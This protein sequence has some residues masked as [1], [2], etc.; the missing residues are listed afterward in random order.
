MSNHLENNFYDII[1]IGC[2]LSGISLVLE[3]CNRT[4][5]K[6]LILEKKKKLENDK[7]WCF[8]NYPINEFTNDSDHIW[9]NIKISCNEKTIIKNDKKFS[10]NNIPSIKLYKKI[11]NTVKKYSNLDILFDQNITNLIEKENS[12]ILESNKKKFK[13]EFVFDS[14]PPQ[15][16]KKK[17]VQHFLGIEYLFEKKIFNKNEVTLM[18]F[19]ENDKA[20]HFFYILPFND[21]RALIETTYFSNNIFNKKKYIRDIDEYIKEKFPQSKFKKIG[22]E[23]G[24]IPMYNL[25]NKNYSKRIFTIGTANNWIRRSSG[26]CFQN[27]F[28]NSKII[29]D[30][31]I[32]KKPILVSQSSLTNFLDSTFCMLLEKNPIESVKV[33]M[34]FFSNLELKIIIKFLTNTNSLL[35]TFKVLW[36]LPKIKLVYYAV[37]TLIKNNGK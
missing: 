3:L 29:V 35:D 23:Q 16:E 2:G 33:L 18:D 8:W 34:A 21:K 10:Y 5:K 22:I 17:L 6:I 30:Q 7:N 20:V 32:K 9:K 13:S 14:R 11:L 25:D 12:V 26:Y 4:K 15:I 27:A 1:V 28:N 36:A 31:I 19:Q 37:I 24:I